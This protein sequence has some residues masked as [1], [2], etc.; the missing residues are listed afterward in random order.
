MNLQRLFLKH[1]IIISDSYMHLEAQLPL[2]CVIKTA[3][4][5]VASQEAHQVHGLSRGEVL[6]N[7]D[8]MIVCSKSERKKRFVCI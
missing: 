8:L 3:Y 1:T 6:T 4:S 5:R 2:C 7:K